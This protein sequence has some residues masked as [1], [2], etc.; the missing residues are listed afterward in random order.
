MGLGALAAAALAP[1]LWPGTAEAACTC[2]CVAGKPHAQCPSVL[3]NPPVCPASVCSAGEA[4]VKSPPITRADN[5]Q[6]VQVVNP[7]TGQV[8]RQKVCK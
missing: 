2:V 5:C 3:E 8:E 4:A 1:V 7:Q 6:I